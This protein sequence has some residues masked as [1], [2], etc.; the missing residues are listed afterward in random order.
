MTLIV[1]KSSLRAWPEAGAGGRGLTG[2]SQG[3]HGS[4]TDVDGSLGFLRSHGFPTHLIQNKELWRGQSYVNLV[5]LCFYSHVWLPS[6]FKTLP[7]HRSLQVENL[8]K[9]WSTNLTNPSAT[10]CE[11]VWTRFAVEIV[12]L[13]GS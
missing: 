4:L 13:S 7:V 10:P 6:T 12:I 11:K 1:R 3:F 8:R 5:L 2:P 9:K